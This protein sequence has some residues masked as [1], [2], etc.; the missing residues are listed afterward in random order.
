MKRIYLFVLILTFSFPVIAS[1]QYW[2]YHLSKV[3]TTQ[4]VQGNNKVYFLSEGG[5]FY[6]DK[7]DSRVQTYTKINGLS[8]S[9]FSGIEYSSATNSLI[10]YYDDAMIDIITEDDEI[11]PINAIKIKNI[12]GNKL[13]YNATC[14]DDLCYL[15]CGFGIV[16]LDLINRE[17]K[18][19]FIIGDNGGFEIVYDVAVDDTCIYAGTPNGIKYAPKDAPNLLDYNYWKRVDNKNVE[20]YNFDYLE[21]GAGRIW[22]IHQS[23]KWHSDRIVSMHDAS[24][25]F[26]EFPDMHVVFNMSIEGNMLTFCGRD[27]T[28]DNLIHVYEKNVGLT[29]SI[30]EYTFDDV[31]VTPFKTDTI[32]IDPRDAIIDKDGVIWIADY[33]YGA[34]RYKDGVFTVINPGGPV[35]N[36]AFSMSLSNN[37]LWIAGGGRNSSWDNLYKSA[38]F[39]SYVPDEN[40]WEAFNSVNK[41]VLKDYKDVTQVLA[42]PGNPNHIYVA[43]WGGGLLEFEDGAYVKTY[44]ETNSELQK[45]LDTGYFLRIGGMDFDS[46]GNLWV[47]N[48]EVENSICVMR[49]SGDWDA[50]KDDNLAYD[51]KLGK[52]IVTQ[53]DDIWTIVPRD[54]TGG[55]FIMSNDGRSKRLLDVVSYFS[56]G[57]EELTTRM[58]DVYDIV[59]DK[60]GE[61]WVG[62]SKGVA[63][64]SS[65]EKV[66]TDEN[67]YA[68]QPGVDLNDG[69]YHPL[70]V[71]ETVTA[72]A[73]DG[74]N[75]KYFGTRSSGVFLIS[76]DGTKEIDHYTAV[77]SDLISNGIISLEYD[78]KNGTL[79]VGTDKGMISLLT[80]SKDSYDQFTNVYAYP[81]PVRSTYEGD[82]YITGLMEDTNVKITTVSGQLVS[83]TTSVGGQATWDGRDLAGNRVHTGVYLVLCASKDGQQS[84]MA[85][86]LFISSNR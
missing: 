51:Y 22:A 82:I 6:Y 80:P 64:Y 25:W 45:A 62:T 27:I 46:K 49:T 13:I 73:V 55:L 30:R 70:L 15:S 67:F 77:N 58:N 40:R 75:R 43:T 57:E 85:K 32:A 38:V 39:Q 76:A 78:G 19:T 65:P 84:A 4:V 16:V 37:K 17:I 33:N 86:I 66:F 7:T 42:T 81:N 63:V 11:H 31:N 56:N 1:N 72:I 41:P 36:G 29:Y 24:T 44:N 68:N 50:F 8:G 69:I 9:D 26:F 79:F 3:H 83:E 54:Q 14:V 59:E 60:E 23:E 21:Y 20:P 2:E 74:G 47:S 35:D 61:I 52:L 18:D 34:I 48:S 53:N 5:I 28:N 10:I 12:G 71:N